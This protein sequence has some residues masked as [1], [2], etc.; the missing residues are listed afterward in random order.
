MKP[1]L[2]DVCCGVGGASRG[3]M[4]AGFHVTGIDIDVQPEYC[5]DW[6]IQDDA[7]TFIQKYGSSYDFIHASPPC[8]KHTAL[9]KGTNKGR[10]YVDILSTTRSALIATGRPWVIENVA[11]APLRKDLMLCGEMFGL[12][13]QRHRFFEFSEDGI[14]PGAWHKP[15][16]GRVSGYRHGEWFDGPYVAVYGDGGGKG[17]VED[18]QR[19]MD[20]RWTKNRQSI[21][22]AIPPAYTRYIGRWVLRSGL[23]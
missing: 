23:T 10:E 20:I 8:L 22:Q 2:L 12:A 1:R 5:G 14:N 3:Y 21:A 15:H 9:T 18:W 17:S 19:A 13:V 11:G 6:F 16:R 7:V 4:N